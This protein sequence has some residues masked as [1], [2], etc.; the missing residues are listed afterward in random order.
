M[1]RRIEGESVVTENE[2]YR[3]MMGD[4]GEDIVIFFVHRSNF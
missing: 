3:G 4:V 1:G 2:Q